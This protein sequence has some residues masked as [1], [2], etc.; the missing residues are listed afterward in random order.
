MQSELPGV[1]VRVKVEVR[2]RVGLGL[3]LNLLL[4]FDTKLHSRLVVVWG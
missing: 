4:G 1:R 2:V 3:G